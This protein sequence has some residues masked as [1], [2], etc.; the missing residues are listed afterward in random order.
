MNIIEHGNKLVLTLNLTK[1]E[2]DKLFDALKKLNKS[3]QT[4][5]FVEVRSTIDEIIEINLKK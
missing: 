5:W 3:K 1:S 2:T 4:D